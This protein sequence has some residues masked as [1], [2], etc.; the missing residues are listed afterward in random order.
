MSSYKIIVIDNAYGIEAWSADVMAGT[1]RGSVMALAARLEATTH[2]APVVKP[3]AIVEPSK[4]KSP[5]R[6]DWLYSPTE[7][8]HPVH[9]DCMLAPKL[10]VPILPKVRARHRKVR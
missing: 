7:T 1:P 4:P 9:D 8:I 3:T 5:V 2:T 6:P 10:S